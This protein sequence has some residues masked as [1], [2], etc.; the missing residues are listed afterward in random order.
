MIVIEKNGVRTGA[1]LDPAADESSGKFTGMWDREVVC[2]ATPKYQVYPASAIS[3]SLL[4]SY[5][6]CQLGPLTS[7]A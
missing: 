6:Y 7:H 1:H 2:S 3:A 5:Q 4:Q